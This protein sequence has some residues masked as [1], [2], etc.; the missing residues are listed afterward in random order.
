[1]GQIAYARV[2][3][4]VFLI[5]F[6]IRQAAASRIVSDILLSSD[7]CFGVTFYLTIY[8]FLMLS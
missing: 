2:P 4:N 1:M 3:Q 6:G 8:L 5:Q 7:A